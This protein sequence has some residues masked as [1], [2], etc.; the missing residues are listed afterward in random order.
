MNELSRDQYLYFLYWNVWKELITEFPVNEGLEKRAI[1]TGIDGFTDCYAIKDILPY[2]NSDDGFIDVTLHK[3]I[4]ES[5]DSR[6]N[7]NLVS[8]IIPTDEA[9]TTVL[10]RADS[11]NNQL[12]NILVTLLRIRG[13]LFS[14]IHMRHVS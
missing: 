2:Q 6:Q 13:L 9:V 7:S 1:K 3:G 10:L 5:W 4:I 11:I 8:V 12:S 14:D